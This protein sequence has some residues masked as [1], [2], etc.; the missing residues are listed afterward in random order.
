MVISKKVKTFNLQSPSGSY[1]KVQGISSF[2]SDVFGVN[3]SGSPKYLS[4]FSELFS[5]VRA[6]K[7]VV[8]W[9]KAKR[10]APKKLKSFKLRS[11]SGAVVTIYNL[12]AFCKDTF[13]VNPSGSAKYLTTFSDM[14]NRDKNTTSAQGWTVK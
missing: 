1:L 13:G 3:P 9:T 14:L 5:G 6:Q 4:S 8:G 10:T 12:S 11:P 2:L 7:D